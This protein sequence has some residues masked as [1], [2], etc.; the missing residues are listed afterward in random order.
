MGI[1]Q[2]SQSSKDIKKQKHKYSL[3]SDTVIHFGTNS[4][5]YLACPLRNITWGHLVTLSVDRETEYDY[6]KQVY[7]DSDSR[8]IFL[9]L[10]DIGTVGFEY[11]S[12][13]TIK[14][15]KINYLSD[16]WISIN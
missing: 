5:I 3:D 1:K 15:I 11:N 12:S 8:R 7:W 13:E 4:V 10:S 16:T 9:T 2:S 6:I 14:K